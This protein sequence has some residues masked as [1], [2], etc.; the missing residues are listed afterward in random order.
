MQYYCPKCST[1]SLEIFDI[2]QFAPD[3]RSDEIV[4][5]LIGCPRCGFRGVAIYE[6]SRRGRMSG[7]NWEHNG[8]RV[9]GDELTVLSEAIRCC[10][11]PNNPRCRCPVHI[12]LGRR[13]FGR[14]VG[15]RGFDILDN[16]AMR[17]EGQR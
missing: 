14:W 2:I 6:E 17:R 10:P 3:S 7:N 8:Y 15:L 1:L 11:E 12:I 4:L 9:G 13:S 5:Q 16:F